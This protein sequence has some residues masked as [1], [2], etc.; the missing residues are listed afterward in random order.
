MKAEPT[1]IEVKPAGG[2]EQLRGAPH[3]VAAIYQ[4]ALSKAKAEQSRDPE[5][6]AIRA[7]RLGGWYRSPSGWKQLT[8]DLREKVNVRQAV[9]QP[10]GTYC[11]YDVDVFYPNS[12]K[13]DSEAESYRPEDIE[14]ICRNTNRA[15]NNGGQKPG[16]IE[17]HPSIYQKA[18]GKQ[19]PCYGSAVNWRMSPRGKGWARCDLIDIQPGFV[20]QLVG[21]KLPG[22]SAYINLDGGGLNRRFG[23]VAALGGD[24]Q[25]L[26]HLPTHEIYSDDSQLCFSATPPKPSRKN[27]ARKTMPYSDK[28]KAA[29]EAVSHAFAACQS[30]EPDAD[31]K[32]DEAKKMF[33]AAFGGEGAPMG[34]D[35]G[36]MGERGEA[37]EGAEGAEAAPEFN[38][39][40]AMPPAGPAAGGAGMTPPPADP[41]AGG[42]TPPPQFSA[43][44]KLP[45]NPSLSGNGS[46]KQKAE[47]SFSADSISSQ[48]I[49][50]PAAAFA[51]TASTTESTLARLAS[52]ENMLVASRRREFAA[53]STANF[54]RGCD[55]L[56]AR[57][58]VIPSQKEL[59]SQ[60]ARSFSSSNPVEAQKQLWSLLC[61]MPTGKTPATVG[62]VFGDEASKGHSFSADELGDDE[63]KQAIKEIQATTGV[64]FSADEMRERLKR[65]YGC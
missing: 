51:A 27:I 34:G 9:P 5:A 4:Q 29:F 43:D 15:I 21:R 42:A 19:A 35:T 2:I 59:D 10:D 60:F 64:A 38:A 16:L 44:T 52:L 57:G 62:T 63:I 61:A 41:A 1:K 55:Q 39:D 23:H 25:A 54:K 13:G 22:L 6:K 24:I 37:G 3:A 36:A 40:E 45:A 56:R 30:E 65:P 8:K 18:M 49:E 33:N 14:A 17:G 46:N 20:K 11:V 58:K 50:D 31:S 53:V 26:A 12:V 7:I 48:F 32:M 47:H 28:Q